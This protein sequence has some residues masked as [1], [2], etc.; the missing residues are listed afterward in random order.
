MTVGQYDVTNGFA[1]TVS[2]LQPPRRPYSKVNRVCSVA[3]GN[4]L[5][6]TWRESFFHSHYKSTEL[7]KTSIFTTSMALLLVMQQHI[8]CCGAI[9]NLP[10]RSNHWLLHMSMTSYSTIIRHHD[11][12]VHWI[13]IQARDKLFVFYIFLDLCFKIIPVKSHWEGFAYIVKV[14]ADLFGNLTVWCSLNLICT[15]GSIFHSLL[16]SLF[17]VPVV[18]STTTII[19]DR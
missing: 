6:V 5:C 10:H 1:N 12:I 2:S 4:W 18:Q 19:N 3:A 11:I 9:N 14:L 15:C 8:I 17:N 13:S 7:Q 16:T